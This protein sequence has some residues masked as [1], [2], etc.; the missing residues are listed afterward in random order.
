MKDISER[1]VRAHLAADRFEHFVGEFRA[2]AAHYPPQ[3]RAT[4]AVPQL[5]ARWRAYREDNVGR[6]REAVQ[7]LTESGFV[8][9]T[10]AIAVVLDVSPGQVFAWLSPGARKQLG[11]VRRPR[12]APSPLIP[13]T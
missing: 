4:N 1:L 11:V 8:V 13:A 5:G 10:E 6:C 9:T 3:R 12:K 7:W 2:A